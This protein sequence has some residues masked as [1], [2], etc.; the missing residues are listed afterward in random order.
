MLGGSFAFSTHAVPRTTMDADVAV[1][2]KL[3]QM[4]GFVEVFRH[5]FYVDAR[6]VKGAL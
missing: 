1:D 2:L 5:D 6:Q 3:E 4:D